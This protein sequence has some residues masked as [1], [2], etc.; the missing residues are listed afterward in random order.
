MVTPVPRQHGEGE[1]TG[2]FQAHQPRTY[3]RQVQCGA[4]QVRQ[5]CDPQHW[6]YHHAHFTDEDM[7]LKEA[8]LIP[9]FRCLKHQGK[10]FPPLCY[11]NELQIHQHVPNVYQWPWGPNSISQKA[12]QFSQSPNCEFPA[13]GSSGTPTLGYNSRATHM[14]AVCFRHFTC[15]NSVSSWPP[16]SVFCLHESVNNT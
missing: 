15:T 5:P 7:L 9:S 10:V 4:S 14:S 13:V 6:C 1:R 3:S 12:F 2:L 16:H 8:P 11:L